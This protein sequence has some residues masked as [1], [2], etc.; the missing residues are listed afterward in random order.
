MPSRFLIRSMKQA[1]RPSFQSLQSINSAVPEL[2]SS[3]SGL[4]THLLLRSLEFVVSIV[5]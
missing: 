4:D 3:P 2:V 1:P 5:N